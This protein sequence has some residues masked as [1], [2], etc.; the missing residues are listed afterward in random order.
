[1][2]FQVKQPKKS[3]HHYKNKSKQNEFNHYRHT[4]LSNHK[5]LL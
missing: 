3:K 4:P 2:P 5:T 1:L